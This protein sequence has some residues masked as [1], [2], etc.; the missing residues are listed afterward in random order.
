MD[1]I[2]ETY[3]KVVRS[4]VDIY[5]E[6]FPREESVSTQAYNGTIRAKAC[7]VAR[8]FLPASTISNVGMF[9]SGQAYEHMLLKMR[10]H[11]S[12]EVRNY[13]NMI[14]VE[15]RKV[16][17]SF[18]K[19]VD[20]ENRGVEWSKYLKDNQ[21]N[22]ENDDIITQLEQDEVRGIKPVIEPV[23]V[24]APMLEAPSPPRMRSPSSEKI[25]TT[26][27]MVP[28]RVQLIEKET[29]SNFTMIILALSA[30]LGAAF[31][32]MR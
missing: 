10:I 31:V 27:D 5:K 6:E 9:A 1:S 25:M 26:V 14:L 24:A 12:E 29:N 19:R 3:S 4:L 2:F 13:A 8:Y 16:I 28:T 17:P 18:L 32:L 22:I 30:T 20:V 7:D 21:E 11:K 23:A 15:L